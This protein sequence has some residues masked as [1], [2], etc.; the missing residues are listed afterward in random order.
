MLCDECCCGNYLESV[1]FQKILG[2]QK[3]IV[4]FPVAID[5]YGNSFLT[6]SL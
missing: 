4:E 5:N 6:I 2:L 3:G 1:C